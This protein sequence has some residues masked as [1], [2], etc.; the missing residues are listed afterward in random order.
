MEGGGIREGLGSPDRTGW[1]NAEGGELGAAA[2]LEG[3]GIREIDS[4]VCLREV[5]RE[6][7]PLGTLALASDVDAAAPIGASD[8]A[9]ARE[10]DRLRDGADIGT[11]N[12]ERLGTSC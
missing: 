9:P 10:E 1:G 6:R 11:G 5:S 3:R 8:R 7:R 12:A 4:G 2:S